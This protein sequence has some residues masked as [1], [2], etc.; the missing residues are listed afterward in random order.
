MPARKIDCCKVDCNYHFVRLSEE[1]LFFLKGHME[2]LAC[3][4]PKAGDRQKRMASDLAERFARHLAH[5]RSLQG[6]EERARTRRQKDRERLSRR[7][8]S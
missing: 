4:D 7:K 2:W 1:Q 5:W 3:C 6:I 8:A